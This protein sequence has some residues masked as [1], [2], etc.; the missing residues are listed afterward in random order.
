MTIHSLEP[1]KFRFGRIFPVGPESIEAYRVLRL[2]GLREHP[3]SFGETPES[4]EAKS[5]QQIVERVEAQK[6]IGG[7]ILAAISS[8]GVLIGTVGLAIN[9]AE[10]SRHRGTLWGMY[11][12]PEARNQGVARALINELLIR[13]ER[14]SEL[15]Q[16]HLAVV[17]TN[18]SAYR[19][20]QGMGF[21]TYGT[22]PKVLK[23]GGQA[24]D[25]YLM[26]KP[27][28]CTTLG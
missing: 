7:V 22:D 2:R 4:F 8:A 23:T 13:A 16:I 3:E 15:E 24:F 12:V 28:S 10:K 26:V 9:E 27:L 11:V 6:R 20:Y 17:T 19:L 25:E 14:I 18:Q 1:D 5:N 21:V